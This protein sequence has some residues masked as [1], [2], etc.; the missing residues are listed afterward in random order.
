MIV[1]FIAL[2]QKKYVKSKILPNGY[3]CIKLCNNGKMVDAYICKLMREYYPKNLQ[4]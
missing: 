4:S 1:V 2:D 3:E